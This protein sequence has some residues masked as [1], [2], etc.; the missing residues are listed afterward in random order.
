MKQP[1]EVCLLE[2]ED[3]GYL[4]WSNNEQG[5]SSFSIRV[6]S[7]RFLLI[8]AFRQHVGFLYASGTVIFLM[9]GSTE[10]DFSLYSLCPP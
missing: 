7:D 6:L 8:S 9:T 2:G 1:A 3:G 4:S 10:E 5:I